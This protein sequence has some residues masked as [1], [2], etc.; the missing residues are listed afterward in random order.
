MSR[1]CFSL[2]VLAL[3]VA[4]V[5][6]TAEAPR[7]PKQALQPFN[8]LIGA[9]RGTGTPEG[10]QA[11]RRQGFWSETLAWEWRFKKDDAWL[12]VAFTKGKHFVGGSLRY[13]PA[14][15]QYQLSLQN[16]DKQQLVFSGDFKDH[17]LTLDRTDDKKNEMQRLVITLLH[18]NRFLYRYEVKQANQSSFRR[19]YQV[20]ATKEGVAFASKGDNSPECIVTGGLG[21]IK[22]AYKGKDYYFCCT[23]CRDAFKDDPEKYIKE[24]EANQKKK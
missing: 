11:Q 21:T 22:L 3:L 18:E 13:L 14:T 15:G 5:P 23:G 4:T 10:T 17:V 16:A 9:W 6:A 7:S 20:G 2:T 19:V 8:V 24:Y 12:N 1:A